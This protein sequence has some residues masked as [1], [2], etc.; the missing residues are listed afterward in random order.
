MFKY[1][2][3]QN[4]WQYISSG[5]CLLFFAHS[6]QNLQGGDWPGLLG[7]NRDGQSQ[8]DAFPITSLAEK[9][10]TKWTLPAGD[11]YAGAAIAQG[12]VVLYDRDNSEDRVRC[13]KLDSGKLIWEQRFESVYRGGID[14][15]TGPRCVPTILPDRIVV[16]SAGGELVSMKRGSGEIDWRRPLQ[17][18]FQADEGYF[19]AGSTPL[20]VEDQIIVN[21]GGKKGGVVS[22]S[23]S[24]GQTRWTATDY[25]ASYASPIMLSELL[26][27]SKPS[28]IVVPTRLKTIGVDSESGKVLWETNFGQRGPTVNAATPIVFDSQLFLTASYGIGNL[29]FNPKGDSGVA[30]TVYQGEAISSQYASPIYLNGL[31]YGSDGREDKGDSSFRCLDAL[32]G[33]IKW[34]E[35]SMPICHCIGV[36]KS[37]LLLIGIDGHVWLLNPSAAGFEAYWKKTIGERTFRALPAL[38]NRLLVVRNTSPNAEWI[39]VD[40]SN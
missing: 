14:S 12:Q 16:Y 7:P 19:G 34:E 27:P 1:S 23:L 24:D 2:F 39:A 38:S 31:I 8:D 9:G 6:A 30:E 28:T 35:K 18:E 33:K 11:G 13:V 22:V 29:C 25:D 37:Q 10:A 15:D 4:F 5:I 36:N 32:T 26:S 40:L 17:R 3:S 20:V 21:V